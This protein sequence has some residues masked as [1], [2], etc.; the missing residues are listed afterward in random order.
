MEALRI[1]M[2]V[3]TDVLV[4]CLRG[5]SQAK[6]WLDEVQSD[7]VEIPGVVAME[8]LMGCRN[9]RELRQ[10]Q[11][12]MNSFRVVWPTSAEFARAYS[13]LA[14][15]RLSTGLGIAAMALDRCVRLYTFN[16]K[17]FRAVPGLDAR[18]PYVRAS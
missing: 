2:L 11:M 1:A 9:Q 18:Q 13:I 10:V 3:D 17:H 6:A 15:L 14:S 4:E 7:E 8:L 5:S 12:L 16:L